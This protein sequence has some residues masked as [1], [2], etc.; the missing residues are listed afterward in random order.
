MSVYQNL[1]DNK[2]SIPPQPHYI[3]CTN[4]GSQINTVTQSSC[5]CG[6]P[7]PGQDKFTLKQRVDRECQRAVLINEFKNDVLEECGLSNHPNKN[8]IFDYV[9]YDRCNQKM[10]DTYYFLAELCPLFLIKD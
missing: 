1:K 6:R 7:I 3:K 9:Y 5:R 4:C 8:K 2:Y 10:E